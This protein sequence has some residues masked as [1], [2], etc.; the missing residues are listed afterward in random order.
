MKLLQTIVS[1]SGFRESDHNPLRVEALKQ[2][3]K[4]ASS[5]ST[6]LLLLP[7]GYFAAE[8]ERQSVSIVEEMDHLAKRSKV[9]LVFGIDLPASPSGKGTRHPV[10]PYFG[11]VCGLTT[12]GPWKQTSDTSTN[13]DDVADED[14]PSLARVVEVAGKQ[15][16]VLL[17]GELYSR[18]ARRSFAELKL[19]LTVDLGHAGMG[20]GLIPAMKSFA[21]YGGCAVAHS[22]HV[23]PPGNA[24]LHFV[25]RR[26]TSQPVPISNCD[27]FGD[28]E[29]W[30]AWRLREV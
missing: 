28:D 13:A 12:A 3:L 20:Q 6:D 14:V 30:I 4:V 17:C 2:V 22:Q 11:S 8:D 24:S 18:W 19:D 1:S 21:R 29:F 10:L 25:N 5:F 26:G 9:S 27:Y 16:G 7:G 23:S 15:I